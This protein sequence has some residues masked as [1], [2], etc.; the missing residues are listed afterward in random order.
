M[1]GVVL[2]TFTSDDF[3]VGP[4]CGR[5]GLCQDSLPGALLLA[6]IA[7]GLLHHRR[8]PPKAE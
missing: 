1:I 4:E 5:L 7:W 2:D 8:R 3:G 6:R